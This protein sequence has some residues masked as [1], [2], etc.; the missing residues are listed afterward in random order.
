MV[1]LCV[2][3]CVCACV[4]VCTCVCVCMQDDGEGVE[5]GHQEGKAAARPSL[6]HKAIVAEQPA[7]KLKLLSPKASSKFTL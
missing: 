6:A 7:K 2:C 3:V 4:C 5:S 1:I